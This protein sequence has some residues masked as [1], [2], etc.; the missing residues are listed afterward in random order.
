MTLKDKLLEDAKNAFLN[1]EEFAEGV[2]YA[3]Y[4]GSPKGIN[5]VVVRERLEASGPDR[6]M[7]LG[8]ECEI[9]IANDVATGV[10]SINKN[11]DKVS[12]PVQVGGTPVS[13]TVVEI[14]GHDEGIWHLR[15]I[16]G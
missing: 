12:F 14:L 2:T 7:S 13:W 15:V 3:P 16:K 4:G 1:V 8:R 6:G 10:T 9:F 11:N 5:A